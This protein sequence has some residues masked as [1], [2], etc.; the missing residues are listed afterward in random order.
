[1]KSVS[2]SFSGNSANI[3]K[4]LGVS[5]S[6]PLNMNVSSMAPNTIT[7]YLPPCYGDNE[8]QSAYLSPLTVMPLKSDGSLCI[9]EAF[10]SSHAQG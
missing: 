4:L 6:P 2:D 10:S 3:N 5:L 8:T 9:L 7:C 1:M